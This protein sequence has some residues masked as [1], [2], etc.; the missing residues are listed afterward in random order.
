M[1]STDIVGDGFDR[2]TELVPE[3]HK[4]VVEEF[5]S[6][7]SCMDKACRH[8]AQESL[9]TLFSL[10]VRQRSI[11]MSCMSMLVS[12]SLRLEFAAA[13]LSSFQVVPLN[14]IQDGKRRFDSGLQNKALIAAVMAGSTRGR[15]WLQK[16]RGNQSSRGLRA[17]FQV[18]RGATA[19]RFG[20]GARR[21]TWSSRRYAGVNRRSR[22]GFAR[23]D[24]A[25]RN[26]R[27]PDSTAGPSSA[28]AQP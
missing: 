20:R 24:R 25:L 11:F 17:A 6:Y 23:R 8:A 26:Q 4:S 15:S 7:L 12:K 22:E 14:L 9:S 10:A 2:L 5:S 1:A 19:D 13:P 28:S 21:G 16:R 18:R 27:A 3:D